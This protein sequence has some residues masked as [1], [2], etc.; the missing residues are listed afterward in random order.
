M[1][2]RPILPAGRARRFFRL[3]FGRAAALWGV[4]VLVFLGIWFVLQPG[5]GEPGSHDVSSVY[6]ACAIGLGLLVAV[7]VLGGRRFNAAN[8]VGIRAIAEGDFAR[9]EREFAGLQKRFRWLS[10][11]AA[12][13][14]F[15]LAIAR[16]YQGKLDDA[17]Q[18]FGKIEATWSMAPRLGPNTACYLAIAYALRGQ[19][20]VARAWQ[21]AADKRI[22]TAALKSTLT[23]FIDFARAVIELREGRDAEVHH[24]LE[25]HW[26]G[27][28]GSLTGATLRPLTVVRAFAAAGAGQERGVGAA[29]RVMQGLGPIRPGEFAMLEV[30]WPEMKRF[31]EVA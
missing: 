7:M 27:L 26:R 1:S 14:G 2:D 19:L 16:L 10:A 22:Q 25:E 15:N 4:L 13:A 28:E 9:A 29:Q 11:Y 31:L 18:R 6:V 23:G 30:E 12:I 5:P 24:W 21:V 17:I 20:D 3:P 8:S